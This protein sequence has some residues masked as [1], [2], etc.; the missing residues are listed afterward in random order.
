MAIWLLLACAPAW[1]PSEIGRF[2]LSPPEGWEIE[3]NYR[4]FG[5][6]TFVVSRG[7]ASMSV[8]MR[9]DTGRAQT[10]PLDLVAGVRALSWG[11]RVGVENSVLVEQD[12][13]VDGRR[14]CAVTGMRRWRTATT[15]Y[16]MVVLRAPGTI[17]ELVLHAPY[18]EL[19]AYAVEWGRFL[20]EFHLAAA[21]EGDI[22][23]FSEDAWRR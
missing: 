15:G 8:S 4:F 1:H 7:A 9:P 2:S 22:P 11:R 18:A 14:A 5:A 13:E 3:R 19:D 20:D 10:L 23:L 16:T 17:V 21:P 6:D 12:I